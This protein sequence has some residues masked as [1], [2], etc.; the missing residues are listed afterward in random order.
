MIWVLV[1]VAWV[2]WATVIALVLW[3]ACASARRR[4]RA[5]VDLEV[6]WLRS[7]I[8]NPNPVLLP[9]DPGP[10]VPVPT[11]PNPTRPSRRGA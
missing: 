5:H 10:P 8:A 11:R 9:P 1:A 6:A 2:L 7:Y 4:D 3:S